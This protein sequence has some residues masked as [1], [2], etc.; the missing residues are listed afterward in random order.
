MMFTAERLLALCP[1]ARADIIDAIAPAFTL[2][3][4]EFEITSLLRRAHMIAQLAHESAGFS[5]L[6]E[7]LDYKAPRISVIWPRLALRA[8]ELAH[9]PEALANAAYANRLGNGGEESGDG[10][11]YRGRGLI[12]ITGRDNYAAAANQPHMPPGVYAHPDG[13]GEP[14]IAVLIALSFW[15]RHGCNELADADN[16]EAITR[17]ING[18]ALA[19]LAERRTLF[20]R[21]KGIF[22]DDVLI[23]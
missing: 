9:R 7:N 11:R 21:A 12:Q 10:W 3:S 8:E 19:G 15:R 14:N 16:I 17:K 6:E 2:H 23:A 5:R 4:P 22:A 1:H 13:A 20:E 18:P